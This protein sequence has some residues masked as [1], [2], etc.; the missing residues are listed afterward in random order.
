MTSLDQN[1]LKFLINLSHNNN[2]EWFN[3]NKPSY[4]EAQQNFIKLVDQIIQDLAIHDASVGRL[5]G[6]NT[7]FRIYR[8]TRFSKDKTPYKNNMGAALSEKGVKKLSHS[9]YYIHIEPGKSFLAGGVHMPESVNLKSI[10]TSISNNADRFLKIINNNN[11]K[12]QL[13]LRGDKLIKV[14]QGFGKDDPMAEYLK[15]KSFTAFHDLTDEMILSEN[16]AAHAV[17]IFKEIHP[18]NQFLNEAIQDLK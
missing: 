4:I 16:F 12:N 8:D 15:Y 3:E 13:E 6:K 14:P 5:E 2:R 9:G 18:F 17:S 1:S 7:V 11:F 10:R